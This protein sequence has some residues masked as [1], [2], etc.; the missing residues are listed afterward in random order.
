MKQG[1]LP[2]LALSKKLH[3]PEVKQHVTSCLLNPYK[4]CD[5]RNG[6]KMISC[7]FIGIL[8]CRSIS[9]DFHYYFLLVRFKDAGWLLA[10][11]SNLTEG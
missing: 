9:S 3:L 2:S 1:K 6:V 11:A 5:D 8:I 4:N 7:H 10:I